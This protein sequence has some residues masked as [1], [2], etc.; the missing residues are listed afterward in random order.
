MTIHDW[1]RRLPFDRLE[2]LAREYGEAAKEDGAYVITPDSATV[3]IPPI[4]TPLGIPRA[5][6]KRVSDDAH[7]ITSGLS[8]LTADLMRAPNPIQ[9]KL[10]GAFGPLEAEALEIGWQK[11]EQLATVRV[12]FL[13][14]EN[15][16]H[17][18][19][20]V[21]ATIPAM[22]GYSDAI[23]A[24]FLR[25]VAKQL[26]KDGDKL[27]DA[28]GRNTDDL[29]N[30]LLAHRQAKSIAIVARQGDAQR[31]E[32]E[33][34]LRRWTKLGMDVQL[35]TPADVRIVDGKGMIGD[36]APD[37]FYRH[38][39]ARRLDPA[40]DFARMCLRADEFGI[41]NPIASHLEVKAM[42]GLLSGAV[43]TADAE[44]IGLTDDEQDAVVRCVPWTRMLS[45]DT[46]RGPNGENIPDLAD[47]TRLHASELVLKRSWDYGGKG[48]FLGA[49]FDGA[50]TQ[51]RVKA[52]I[53]RD[54]SWT[55][56]VDFALADK[57]AW[58]VQELVHAQP[59]T[60][61][62]DGRE[63]PLYVD[64]SAFTN[65]GVAVRPAGG[66]VRA[67]ESRIVNILGG[68]GLAPLVLEEVLQELMS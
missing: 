3:A 46:T 37:L 27:V 29:L 25:A 40:S 13:V 39:F 23:A 11:A 7:A 61:S 15:G 17:R 59:V 65:L 10:F 42:L 20:E 55:E 9:Q 68:G 2:T 56:L 5:R 24:A 4:L 41:L 43:G 44:R 34:Y 26:G 28:N 47:W 45:G 1:L 22:Q 57:D 38:I 66:A 54:A 60:M 8:R 12:D 62:R 18:A 6:M 50:S 63:R 30:S 67:A 53:G 51:A 21:N 35:V 31:G 33:H 16:Q 48:V 64:L 49:D 14:D 58:V 32:L 36:R 52:L 19:L